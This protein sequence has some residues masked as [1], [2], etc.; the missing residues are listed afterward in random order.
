VDMKVDSYM[1]CADL[2]QVVDMKMDSY[3]VCADCIASLALVLPTV[4]RCHL[5]RDY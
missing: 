1:V 3:M 4:S 2:R 5:D